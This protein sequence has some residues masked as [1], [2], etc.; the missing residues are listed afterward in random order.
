MQFSLNLYI[1]GE[2]SK[3]NVSHGLQEPQFMVYTILPATK[4]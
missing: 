2:E 3:L 4:A 1:E